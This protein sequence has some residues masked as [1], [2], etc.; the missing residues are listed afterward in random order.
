LAVANRP[1]E[2]SSDVGI[3]HTDESPAVAPPVAAHRH[4][5]IKEEIAWHVEVLRA[6]CEHDPQ[7]KAAVMQKLV[8]SGLRQP[9]KKK[10]ATSKTH[11]QTN[12]KR[13]AAAEERQT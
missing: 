1:P 3:A 9:N 7:T 2:I 11:K 6:F 12:G 5:T 13:R 8:Y 10:N 4:P